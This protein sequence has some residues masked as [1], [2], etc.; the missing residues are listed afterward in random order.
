MIR[1]TVTMIFCSAA[2]LLAGGGG[3][4]DS[5]I[6]Q[7]EDVQ[8]S[9]YPSAQAVKAFAFNGAILWYTDGATFK[10]LNALKKK[11]S[12]EPSVA[13]VNPADVTCMA[14]D[15]AGAFWFGT[16]TGLVMMTAKTNTRFTAQTGLADDGVLCISAAG[17]KVWIGTA[18]GASNYSA[19]AWRTYTSKDGLID[20]KI[21]CICTDDPGRTWFGTEKG[22]SSFDGGAWKSYSMKTGMSWNDTRALG[23]DRK[24]NV[25]WA[26]VG[27]SDIN[28]W[29][30]KE[31]RQYL[32]IQSGITSIMA[33]TKSRIWF[34]HE[35]G[36][37]KFNGDEWV[38]DAGKLGITI[39]QVSQ[40]LRDAE[41]NL[42]FG[43]EKG[44][45]K[46]TNPYLH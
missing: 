12:E 33:D 8:W 26:A 2:V 10:S 32:G 5:V 46:M 31:W 25:V 41:G 4:A 36:L 28:S 14:A 39:S 22:M 17:A 43:A 19:G 20:D 29:D 11:L 40:M 45:I 27:E 9:T 38:G 6:Y 35:G 7:T 23:F 1:R 16:Q 21:K 30:G 3:K 15:N 24:T 42:W 34:G 13:G 44:V 37:I 18:K